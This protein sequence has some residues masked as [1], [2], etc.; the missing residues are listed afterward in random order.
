MFIA[1]KCFSYTRWGPRASTL[2]VTNRYTNATYVW[3]VHSSSHCIVVV[4]VLMVSLNNTQYYMFGEIQNPYTCSIMF[5]NFHKA[6]RYF[7]TSSVSQFDKFRTGIVDLWNKR[8]YQKV[9]ISSLLHVLWWSYL[10]QL[11]FN[12]R[13]VHYVF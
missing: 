8:K 6:S 12:F 2:S 4:L 9:N 1:W 10:C 7:I 13:T 5:D 3:N 11:I